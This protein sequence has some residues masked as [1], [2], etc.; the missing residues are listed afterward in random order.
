MWN[1]TLFI[2]IIPIILFSG[3]TLLL[4]MLLL[5]LMSTSISRLFNWL[6]KIIRIRY[7]KDKKKSSSRQAK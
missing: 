5:S 6:K 2:I 1:G 7:E 3:L 4:A